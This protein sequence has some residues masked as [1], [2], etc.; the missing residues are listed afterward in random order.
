MDILPY[1]VVAFL[2]AGFIK[3]VVGFGFPIVALI[4]LTLATGLL[5]ALALIVVP[6]LLT[7]VWQ[8]LAGVHLRAIL[9]RMGI[10]FLCA[11]A[12]ILATSQFLKTSDTNLLTGLL[13]CVLFVFAVS[14]LMRLQISVPAER[15]KPL[16][17]VLGSLNGALTGLTGSFMVPS[18]LYMQALGFPRDM[19]VQAMGVFFF[20]STLTLT[21][22]LGFNDLISME[23]VGLS[24][25]AL[26]P[27]F[28]GLYGGRWLRRRIDEA[29]FQIVF[30]AGVMVLGAYIALMALRQLL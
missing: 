3:G 19:L 23:A 13:G 24:T 11:V 2:I 14:R 18:V 25:A 10:Y 9:A 20:V 8:A 28:A 16:S 29:R 30:L 21:L 1:A 27:S 17:F 15:E 4:V 6:T 12:G 7:N 26:I 22:S 5:D